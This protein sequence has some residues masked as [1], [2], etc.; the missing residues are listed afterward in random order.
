MFSQEYVPVYSRLQEVTLVELSIRIAGVLSYW[1]MQYLSLSLMYGFLSFLAVLVHLSDVEE[2]PQ[3]FGPMNETWSI[4]RFW[5]RFYH[6]NIR[7]G[8]SS[9]AHFLTYSCL[10]LTTG[11]FF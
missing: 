7:R 11:G 1:A 5:G 3:V 8:C 10:R 4:A 2:W 6:Q 9:I